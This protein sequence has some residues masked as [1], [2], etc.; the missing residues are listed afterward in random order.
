MS[1]I[2][3]MNE[4][5]K[6]GHDFLLGVFS[7]IVDLVKNLIFLVII[8]ICFLMVILGIISDL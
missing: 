4:F 8:S 7:L 6:F 1:Q 3:L 5:F 2:G